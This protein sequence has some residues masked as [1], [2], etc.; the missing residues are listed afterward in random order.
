M[1]TM[2]ITIPFNRFKIFNTIGFIIICLSIGQLAAILFTSLFYD[3][4][5]IQLLETLKNPSKID[6]GLIIFLSLFYSLF[7]FLIIPVIY[8]L[9]KRVTSLS[10][11]FKENK[12]QI[13][14]FLLS[15]ILIFTIIPVV[16]IL[17]KFNQGIE[18]PV[19]LSDLESYFKKSEEGGRKLTSSILSS[20]ES[21]D[22]IIAILIM[23][24]IPGIVEEFFFCGIVQMQ[25]Q[26]ILKNYHY[27]IWLAAFLFSFFHF[28]F[29]GFI[30]RMILG[31]L[32]GYIFVWSK[33]IWYPCAAHITNNLIAVLISYYFGPQFLITEGESLLSTFLIIFSLIMSGLIILFFKRTED[34]KRLSA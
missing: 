25:L 29:Y 1:Q 10:F 33:N 11:L 17:I 8:L 21:K 20:G 6:K 9:F 26:D 31:G 28:Q 18:F 34:A 19:W 14:P 5:T 24:V 2:K 22:L 23:A 12:I 32:F 4:N 3:I 16:T 7:S 13:T 27:A 30:P 15:I